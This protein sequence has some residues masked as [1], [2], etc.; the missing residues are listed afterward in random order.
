MV[1][2]NKLTDEQTKQANA[3]KGLYIAALVFAGIALLGKLIYVATGNESFMKAVRRSALS[4]LGAAG[5]AGSALDR[6]V[7]VALDGPVVIAVVL[8]A[9]AVA[10]QQHVITN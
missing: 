5:A 9:V 8:L 2:N 7:S 1:N 10:I 3:V 6:L 4:G